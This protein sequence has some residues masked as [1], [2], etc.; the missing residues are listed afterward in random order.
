M[1]KLFNPEVLGSGIKLPKAPTLPNHAV[2]KVDLEGFVQ[3]QRIT[4]TN[5]LSVTIP[6][7]ADD[8]FIQCYDEHKRSF[9]P[10]SIEETDDDI[11]VKFFVNQTGVIRVLFIGGS[12]GN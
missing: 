10:D 11:E 9:T 3:A 6:K 8:F 4:I 7:L 12:S 2:R 1:T 5:V